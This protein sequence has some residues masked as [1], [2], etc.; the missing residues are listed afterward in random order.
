[1]SVEIRIPKGAFEEDEKALK[2][3]FEN[4]TISGRIEPNTPKERLKRILSR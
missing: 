1:M 2:E 4:M 3:A